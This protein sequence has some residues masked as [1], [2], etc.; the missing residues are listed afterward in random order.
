ML[1]VSIASILKISRD[2]RLAQRMWRAI[3]GVVK[4]MPFYWPFGFDQ[5]WPLVTMNVG[6]SP[7]GERRCFSSSAVGCSRHMKLVFWISPHNTEKL[8]ECQITSKVARN[9]LWLRGYVRLDLWSILPIL[10]CPLD[11]GHLCQTGVGEWGGGIRWR[12]VWRGGEG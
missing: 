3:S 7:V 1:K 5:M 9:G 6:F 2:I 11:C 12:G 8:S 4:T 10:C